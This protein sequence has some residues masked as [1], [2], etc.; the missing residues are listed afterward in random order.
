MKVFQG[1]PVRIA[2]AIV[3]AALVHLAQVHARGLVQS[4]RVENR[5][6]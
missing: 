3:L 1:K 4:D 5:T 6:G 2:A